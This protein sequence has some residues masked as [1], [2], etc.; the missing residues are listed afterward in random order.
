MC[1]RR[2]PTDLV[3]IADEVAAEV[4]LTWSA[5]LTDR[6]GGPLTGLTTYIVFR[7]KGTANTPLSIATLPA[8]QT[9]YIDAGLEEATVYFYSLQALDPS[10]NRSVRATAPGVTTL[11]G[12]GAVG[13]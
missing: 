5:P 1:R 3:A 12:A 7:S 2:P 10:E 9:R 4:E 8:T 13:A 11:G 6:T